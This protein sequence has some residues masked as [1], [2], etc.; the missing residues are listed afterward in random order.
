MLRGEHAGSAACVAV[1][2]ALW[3]LLDPRTIL[4]SRGDGRLHV[5]FV[6]VGQGDA[7]FVVFP[8]GSTLLVD[9]GGLSSA[10]FD[11]GDRVVAP[12]IRDAGFYR[13]DYL[14][15]THGDPDHIGGAAS[16]PRGIPAARGLGR[17]PGS[18][19]RRL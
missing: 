12:V 14:A 4:A 9:A 16:D 11:V 7:I 3:I 6:D 2:T 17:Y 18:A 19:F 8:H 15:L 5:T 10:S 1:A 13:L